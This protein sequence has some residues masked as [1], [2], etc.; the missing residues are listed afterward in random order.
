MDD[1]FRR[2]ILNFKLTFKTHN[3]LTLAGGFNLWIS[4]T[5]FT[6][7]YR[8][9]N[10]IWIDH[11][12][13]DDYWRFKWANQL[14]RK[15]TNN[16]GNSTPCNKFKKI[17]DENGLAGIGFIGLL[18]TWCNNNPRIAG[19]F[20]KQ[21]RTVANQQWFNLYKDARVQILSITGSYHYPIFSIDELLERGR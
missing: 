13:L 7:N 20:E 14:S 17:L 16:V 19:V 12:S 6:N 5:S 10:Q 4:I 18:F 9:K 3:K 2:T 15:F 11:L 8:R 21:D 1:S